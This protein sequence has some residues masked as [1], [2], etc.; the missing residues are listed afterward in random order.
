MEVSLSMQETTLSNEASANNNSCGHAGYE[1]RF[2]RVKSSGQ[3]VTWI[4]R[5]LFNEPIK[6]VN[7]PKKKTVYKD[8]IL[9]S[10]TFVK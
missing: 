10:D 6:Y 2:L 7:I 1:A 8:I 4:C 5:N 3:A 9:I